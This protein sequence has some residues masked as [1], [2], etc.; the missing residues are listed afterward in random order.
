MIG[1]A[2]VAGHVLLRSLGD[3]VNGFADAGEFGLDEIQ[4]SESSY[5][6]L[7]ES[8]QLRGNIA[9]ADRGRHCLKQHAAI[10]PRRLAIR[11]CDR[12]AKL[13]RQALQLLLLFLGDIG[14]GGRNRFRCGFGG[15]TGRVDPFCRL[16]SG[17]WVG[18]L[19]ADLL[20]HPF[21]FFVH[22][23]SFR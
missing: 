20:L 10:F 19:A 23:N 14:L 22:F 6:F 15:I 3:Q 9:H 2:V 1:V 13:L 16:R 17:R 11:F 5:E 4:L 12:G 7:L 8:I 18:R 21:C